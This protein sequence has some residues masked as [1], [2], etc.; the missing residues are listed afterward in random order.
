MAGTY[1]SVG[2]MM[3]MCFIAQFLEILHPLVGYTKGSALE[4][5]LQ[6]FEILNCN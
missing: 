3:R 4:A 6:V 1:E 5:A 2:W